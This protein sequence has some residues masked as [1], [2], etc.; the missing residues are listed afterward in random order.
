MESVNETLRTSSVKDGRPT[1]FWM[2]PE[3]RDEK[4]AFF[5]YYLWQGTHTFSYMARATTSGSFRTAPAQ[6][7]P[8]Y[9]PEVWG[10]SGS[11]VIDILP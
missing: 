3:Y 5:G 8:M 6:I 1:S 2:H 4:T 9:T 11:V 7:Y 10:R